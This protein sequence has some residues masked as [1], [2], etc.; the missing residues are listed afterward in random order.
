[1]AKIAISGYLAVCNQKGQRVHGYPN[2][3]KLASLE[4]TLV[5]NYYPPTGRVT[6]AEFRATSGAKKLKCPCPLENEEL[7]ED[8]GDGK[9]DGQP[10]TDLQNP[11]LLNRHQRPRSRSQLSKC[12]L[13]SL[14]PC[15]ALAFLNLKLVDQPILTCAGL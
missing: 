9:V 11:P 14:N 15:H 5:R 4:G 6:G 13:V 3:N 10:M 12:P 2:G 7:D 1:M 8:W